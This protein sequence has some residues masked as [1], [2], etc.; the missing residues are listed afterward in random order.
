MNDH[1]IIESIK[2]EYSTVL[3]E[4]GI[5]ENFKNYLKSGYYDSEYGNRYKVSG[6]A[7]SEKFDL[8]GKQVCQMCDTPVNDEKDITYQKH[9]FCSIACL[10]R[11][12]DNKERGFNY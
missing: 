4:R 5:P 1:C 8:V 11:Y 7:R 12:V 10:I 2:K 6:V 9:C 3:D